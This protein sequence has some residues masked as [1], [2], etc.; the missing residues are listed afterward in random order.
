MGTAFDLNK[1]LGD[2][3]LFNSEIET[4]SDRACAIVSAAFLDNTIQNIIM[5]FLCKDSST[6]DR[7]LFNQNGPLSTFSSKVIIAYRLG[8]ISKKEYDNLNVIRKIR[9]C[10]AHDLTVNSFE[11][12]DVKQLLLSN[13]P[14]E[15]MLPPINI[16]ISYNENGNIITPTPQ[17]FIKIVFDDKLYNIMLPKF[18]CPKFRTIDR[19]NLRSIFLGIVYV[20]QESLSSRRLVAI[21]EQRK[22]AEEFNNNV[23]VAGYRVAYLE[24]TVKSQID[25]INQLKED[26]EI[27]LKVIDSELLP[28]E[29]NESLI[30]VKSEIQ[31]SLD[32]I[33]SLLNNYKDIPQTIE[34]ALLIHSHRILK[35]CDSVLSKK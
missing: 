27:K 33:E 15:K 29:N 11:T 22:N 18:P 9:N 34:N 32:Q 14:N 8:L 25:R 10:F 1:E 17:E 35:Y 19:N 2:I 23:D 26:Y 21:I 4:T 3:N 31:K 7:A 13:V 30:I 6:Q 12:P 28:D 20:L 16:S 24:N 5:S